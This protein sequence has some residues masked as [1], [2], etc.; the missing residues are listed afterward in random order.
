M[1]TTQPVLVCH[2]LP[3]ALRKPTVLA[4]FDGLKSLENFVLVSDHPQTPVLA[5]LQEERPGLFEWSPLEEGPG[6]W[7]TEV[8]RRLGL[9]TLREVSEAL[10]WDHDRLD[11]LERLAHSEREAG[12]LNAAQQTFR[13]FANG[14]R[15]HIAV[16]DQIIFPEF[17]QRSGLSPNVGPT[18]VLRAEHRELEVLLNEMEQAMADP[19]A[20]IAGSRAEL[21]RLLAHHNT[22]EEQVL[23]PG[24]DRLMNAEERDDLVR[25][26]Q[27]FS[28]R[29][30]Q[31]RVD[32]RLEQ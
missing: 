27:H 5:L 25:R 9:S 6:E 31:Q 26:A 7:R 16:E 10:S 11:E 2:S 18:A 20:P 29:P 12:H 17:E 32:E 28:S 13:I 4:T 23:Y 8:T 21:K 15:R 1:A 19:A 24:T 22:K 30:G 3:A 14:L